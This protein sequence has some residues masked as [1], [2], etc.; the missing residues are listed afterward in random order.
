MRQLYYDYLILDDLRKTLSEDSPRHCSITYALLE[1]K[2][3][4][5]DYTSEEVALARK[6]L[7]KE[8]SKKGGTPSLKFSA[9]G[10]SHLDLAWLWPIRETKRKAIRTF[11][12]QLEMIERYPDYVYGASQPQQYEWIKQNEPDLY[13]RIKR[14]VENGRI[15]PQGCMWVEPDT[16]VPCGES[17]VRQIFYGK[18]FFKEE[19]GKEID[20]LW[21]PDVFGFSAALPQLCAKS[22]VKYLCTIKMSW[23]WVTKFPYN[24]FIWKGIS[25]DS[26]LVHM[27]PEGDYNSMA[28]PTNVHKAVKNYQEKGKV[29]NALLLYGIGDGGAGPAPRHL[30]ALKRMKNL[31]GLPPVKQESS[32]AFFKKLEKQSKQLETYKG[33]M[34]L[35][36]HQGTY[37]SQGYNKKHNKTLENMLHDLEAAY[38]I[39]SKTDG[40]VFPQAAVDEIWKEVLLYQFHDILPGSCIKRVYD[41]TEEAYCRLEQSVQ[42][43]LDKIVVKEKPNAVFNSLGFAVQDV[44]ENAGKF[45]SITAKPLGYTLLSEGKEIKKLNCYADKYTLSNDKLVAKFNDEGILVS[46]IRKKDGRNAL[47]A[48]GGNVLSVYHDECSWICGDAWDIDPLY[49]QAPPEYFV[50]TDVK[51]YIEG[52]CAVREQTF[53][54]GASTLCQKI[55]LKHGSE[56]L[57]F[58]TTVDWQETNKMLRADFHTDLQ[59]DFVTCGIQF[60]N[61]KRTTK[62]NTATE[63]IQF[64][65]CAHRYSQ[66]CENNYKF[67]VLSDC[68]YGYRAKD[69][70]LSLNLLRSPE[71]PATEAKGIHTFR[72]GVYCGENANDVERVSHAFING[73]KPCFAKGEYSFASMDKENIL[74]DTLKPANNGKG[75]ILRLFESS[76]QKTTCKLVLGDSVERVTLCN[77]LEKEEKVLPLKNGKV[78]LTFKPFEICTLRVE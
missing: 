15:E 26:V 76:G 2:N 16:N 57:E 67:A 45:Y 32:N 41:E 6:V 11:A 68:K 20:T 25:D 38:A 71:Y 30:E 43:L 3:I 77:L 74:I 50:L 56:Y 37:T 60:G 78:Q 64:E 4:L 54:Y 24:S 70:L 73:L 52:A 5:K 19:F 21:L 33:E 42:A 29:E 51:S 53:R 34:Y 39:A 66:L 28:F 65:I 36:A 35:E 44:V 72:Y 23:N 58:E 69:G 59:S 31:D 40:I 7:G 75:Q 12:T 49:Y 14:A 63:K 62:E 8:L 18:Q 61:I 13:Q 10:H 9:V 47:T 1:V 46:V 22:D 48:K 27:P 55:K 17:L